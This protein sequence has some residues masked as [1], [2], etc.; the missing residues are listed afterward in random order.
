VVN[1]FTG[2]TLAE[3]KEAI[4]DANCDEGE[5]GGKKWN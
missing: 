5:E 3:M 1:A 2:Q 4:I